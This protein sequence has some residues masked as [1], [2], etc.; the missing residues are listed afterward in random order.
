MNVRLIWCV[1][2]AVL[3]SLVPAPAASQGAGAQ[4]GVQKVAAQ[5]PTGLQ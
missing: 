3:L 1:V 4:G 5:L 2:T